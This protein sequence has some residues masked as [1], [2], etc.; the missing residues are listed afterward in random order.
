M[1]RTM[2]AFLLSSQEPLDHTVER[3]NCNYV[4]RLY[5]NRP[6]KVMNSRCCCDDMTYE[7]EPGAR[8]GQEQSTRSGLDPAAADMWNKKSPAPGKRVRGGNPRSNDA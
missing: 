8:M 2:C 1:R 7:S 5:G 4:G 3:V 6:A